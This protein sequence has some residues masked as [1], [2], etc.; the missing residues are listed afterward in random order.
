[1][2]QDESDKAIAEFLANGGKIQYIPAGVGSPTA[3]TNMWGRKKKV[4]EPV[5]EVVEVVEEVEVV[6]DET[7]DDDTVV[8]VDDDEDIE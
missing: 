8:F 3:T 4:A 7:I 5:E 1:M 6:E 2:T